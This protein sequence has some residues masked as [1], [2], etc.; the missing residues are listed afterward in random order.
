[1]NRCVARGEDGR[2]P[3]EVALFE[4]HLV[5]AD[6]GGR[7]AMLQGFEE[8]LGHWPLAFR[9]EATCSS[10]WGAGFRGIQE[11][12]KPHGGFSLGMPGCLRRAVMPYIAPAKGGSD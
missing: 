2:F 6:G 1:M 9:G 5:V 4:F 8:Q 10:G 11:R 7:D 12:S 3:V